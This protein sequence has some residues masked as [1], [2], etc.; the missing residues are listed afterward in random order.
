MNLPPLHNLEPGQKIALITGGEGDLASALIAELASKVYF[1]LHP[2]RTELD[3]TSAESVNGYF[4]KIPNVDFLINNAGVKCDSLLTKMSEQEWQQVMQVNLKGAF[5][6]SQAAAR[7]MMRNERRCGHILNVGSNSALT[8]PVGQANYAASKAGLIGFTKTLARE[9][10]PENIR[11]NCVLP[12]WLETK[13]TSN[14]AAAARAH[15]LSE[16]VLG[17]F[18]TTEE[19][20]RAMVFLD[21]LQH[22]SGQVIHL[23]NRITP[24]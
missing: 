17:R 9:L 24:Y 16:H 18:N 5:L 14:V 2:N 8:G 21:S 19:A 12:G 20:A 22:L 1:V 7:L 11:V 15:A 4:S 6:A 10:G 3:V 23:D 13:F